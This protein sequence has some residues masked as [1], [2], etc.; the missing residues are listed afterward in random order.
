[1]RAQFYRTLRDLDRYVLFRYTREFSGGPML[2]ELVAAGTR[3][4]CDAAKRL[5]ERAP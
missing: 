3:E 4:A 2:R 5:F 1:M